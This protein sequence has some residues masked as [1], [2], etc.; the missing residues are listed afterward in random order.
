MRGYLKYNCATISNSNDEYK[1][2]IGQPDT[3]SVYIALV[4]SP[5]PIEIRTNPKNRQLF[6]K[7]APYVVAYGQFQ[8]GETIPDYIPF[9][10]TLDYNSTDRVPT[11]ILIVASAS[12]YGDF[13]TGGVGSVLCIDD[14]ELLYDY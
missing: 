12:K 9:E 11:Y 6:D 8:S 13:F 3:C 2:L 14:L 1:H 7:N 4:D 5:Q 10:I